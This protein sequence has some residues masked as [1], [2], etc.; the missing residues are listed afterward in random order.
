M[1]ETVQANSAAEGLICPG[2]LSAAAEL[3]WDTALCFAPSSSTCPLSLIFTVL[4]QATD[5]PF[6]NAQQLRGAMPTHLARLPA[7]RGVVYDGDVK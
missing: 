4:N 1:R 6:L 7:R 5:F 2:L 3:E